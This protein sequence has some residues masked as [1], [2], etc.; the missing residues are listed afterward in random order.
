MDSRFWIK[1]NFCSTDYSWLST[2]HLL[3]SLERSS[4]KQVAWNIL[5]NTANQQ[6]SECS[7]FPLLSSPKNHGN[8]PPASLSSFSCAFLGEVLAIKRG[9]K[10][11]ELK[12]NQSRSW[13][14]SERVFLKILNRNRQAVGKWG[15]FPN[16]VYLGCSSR[17][18]WFYNHTGPYW[19]GF[20]HLY[21]FISHMEFISVVILSLCSPQLHPQFSSTSSHVPFWDDGPRAEG[22][23]QPELCSVFSPTGV[24]KLRMSP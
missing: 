17:F 14:E 21:P 7:L 10:I 4:K 20:I 22:S 18:Q 6:C 1:H 24:L 13:W 19:Y 5:R 11:S 2:N 3:C 15:R 23:H 9:W 12:G 8:C 16:M